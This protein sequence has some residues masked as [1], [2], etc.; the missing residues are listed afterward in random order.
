VIKELEFLG[1]RCGGLS[2]QWKGVFIKD[3]MSRDDDAIR[4]EVKTA[5]PF[6]IRRIAKEDAQSGARSEFMG[7]SC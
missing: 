2:R 7:R 6:V 4:L 3:N 1:T 5:V